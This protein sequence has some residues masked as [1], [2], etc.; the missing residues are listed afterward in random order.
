MILQEIGEGHW[1]VPGLCEKDRWN[2]EKQ[3]D[4]ESVKSI[5][6]AVYQRI[7]RLTQNIDVVIE[8]SPPNMMRIEALAAQF[9]SCSF[10]ANNR[11]PYAHCSSMLYRLYEADTLDSAQRKQVLQ[12]YALDW[13]LRSVKIH[14]LCGRLDMPL[15]TYEQFCQDPGAL[16]PKLSLPGDITGSIKIHGEVKVKDYAAQGIVNQNERQIANLRAEEIAHMNQVLAKYER[17][18]DF[19]G[20]QLLR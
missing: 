2:P 15:I 3:V 13:S 7:N 20:Y 12:S 5:W 8:K 16:L 9:R 1:L 18:L 4:Y 6:L 10:L 11:D 17:L 14:E 19:F